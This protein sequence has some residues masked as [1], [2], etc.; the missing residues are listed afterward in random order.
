MFTIQ[1]FCF[2]PHSKNKLHGYFKTLDVITGASVNKVNLF[3]F[4]STPLVSTAVTVGTQVPPERRV[5]S[6]FTFPHWI[7]PFQNL[8]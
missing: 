7:Y 1:F 6:V 2:Y 5:T 8:F 3:Q 4:L